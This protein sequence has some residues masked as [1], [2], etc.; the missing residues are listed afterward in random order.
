MFFMIAAL[1]II[2]ETA[3]L[4]DSTVNDL[5]RIVCHL[6]M[7]S[8]WLLL[9]NIGNPGNG[10]EGSTTFCWQEQPCCSRPS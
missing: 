9:I 5:V 10:A 1:K 2:W 3:E 6:C 8:D 4:M 7:Q